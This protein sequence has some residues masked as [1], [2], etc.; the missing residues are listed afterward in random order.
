MSKTFETLLN[1]VRAG[2]SRDRYDELK[3]EYEEYMLIAR[4]EAAIKIT[5]AR[6][7][8]GILDNPEYDKAKKVQ[9]EVEK[10]IAKYRRVLIEAKVTD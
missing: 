9:L 10:V 2:I 6:E 3:R 4:H 1:E 5:E 7:L 8:G